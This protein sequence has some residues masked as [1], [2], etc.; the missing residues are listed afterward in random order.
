MGQYYKPM[1]LAKNKTTILKWLYSHDYDNGLKLMEHSWLG[2][3]F[4]RAFTS[5]IYRNPQIVVWGGDYAEPCKG[6]KTNAYSRCSEKT[7]I[8]PSLIVFEE[9]CRYII[10]HTQK[11]FVD[12]TKVPEIT[13]GWAKGHDYR[14][15]PLPLLTCEGNGGGGGDFFGK[16]P[17]NLVG[18]WARNL[19]SV[20]SVLP[21]GYTELLFNLVEE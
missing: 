14:I 21:S 11:V 9:D 12:T 17:K 3:N 19:V 2:N 20:D 7:R 13:A 8:D 15:H 16:D 4:V 5:L 6:R 18:S 1:T 10:N